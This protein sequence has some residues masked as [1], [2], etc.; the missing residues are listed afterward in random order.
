MRSEISAQKYHCQGVHVQTANVYRF[1][2]SKWWFE[3][4]CHSSI[5]ACKW[6]H[7]A[8]QKYTQHI[9]HWTVGIE[10]ILKIIENIQTF[11][12]V[13]NMYM[14]CV[15]AYGDNNGFRNSKR[16]TSYRRYT[17]F[18]QE[19]L[20]L[21]DLLLLHTSTR[22]GINIF[23]MRTCIPDGFYFFPVSHWLYIQI[24]NRS[25]RHYNK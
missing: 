17:V 6:A 25:T 7:T 11:Q 21:F 5:S 8:S 4:F 23:L 12:C 14:R 10:L 20:I 16:I 3:G 22:G 18:T 2:L 13:H 1:D 9:Q 15:I 24:R 19:F